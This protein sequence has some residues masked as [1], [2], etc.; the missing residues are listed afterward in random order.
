VEGEVDDSEP[1]VCFA[2]ERSKLKADGIHWRAFLPSSEGVRS[3]FRIVNLTT[4]EVSAIG[5]FVAGER[6]KTLYGWGELRAEE[7]RQKL[8]VRREEPPERHAIIAPWPA[9]TTE[10]ERAAVHFAS[11]AKTTRV[12]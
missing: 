6:Q 3:V 2:V 1:L 4:D 12:G 7:V 11:L 5:K 8:P 9:D 10:R